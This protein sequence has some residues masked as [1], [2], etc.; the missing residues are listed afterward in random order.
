MKIIHIVNDETMCNTGSFRSR[1][2]IN[3]D[4]TVWR[5]RLCEELISEPIGSKE[6]DHQRKFFLA[7]VPAFADMN[8]ADLAIVEF[9]KIKKTGDYDAVASKG[10]CLY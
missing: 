8:Y 5:E 9:E 10:S 4:I 3:R 6:F 2:G 7:L 1:I